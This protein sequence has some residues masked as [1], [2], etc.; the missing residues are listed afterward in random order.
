MMKFIAMHDL[1]RAGCRECTE[2]T[3]YTTMKKNTII[4]IISSL[5]VLLFVYAAVTKLLDYQT[6]NLQLRKSPFL[7]QFAGLTTWMLPIGEI[8]VAI[9]LTVRH[10][11]II[12][13]YASLFLM[14]M[15]SAY[16]YIMLKYSYDIPCSCGGILSKMGW[17]EHFWFNVG[18]TILSAL[19]IVFSAKKYNS[20]GRVAKPIPITAT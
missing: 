13:L 11:R 12:G 20:H 19:G 10:T 2:L 6:F 7:T 1:E 17:V 14:T 16:I 8:F 4:E 5:L 18:F 3:P 15:F 9:L